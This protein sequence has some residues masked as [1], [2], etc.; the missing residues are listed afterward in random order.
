MYSLLTPVRYVLNPRL[1]LTTSL[2]SVM[3]F[4]SPGAGYIVGTL[5]GG[6]WADYT[7]KTWAKKRGYRLPEDR[8]RSSLLFIGFILP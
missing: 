6:R 8:L 7:V 2:Q 3:L 4:I 5:I 1:N